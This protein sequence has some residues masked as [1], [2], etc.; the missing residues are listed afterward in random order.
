[1]NNAQRKDMSRNLYTEEEIILCTYL[2]LY[3]TSEFNEIDIHRI[4]NRPVSS[5]KMKIQNIA[6]MLDEEGIKRHSRIKGLS[7]LPTGKKG[8]RT[9]WNWVEKLV[10]LSK[11]DLFSKCETIL[12]TQ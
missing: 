7:G 6:A 1:M 11:D 8:R 4:F 12:N 5:I 10:R 2:A 9:N 3:S